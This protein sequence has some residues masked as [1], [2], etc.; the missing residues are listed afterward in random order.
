MYEDCAQAR[1]SIEMEQYILNNDEVGQKFMRLFIDKAKSGVDVHLLCDEVGSRSF[2]N[3]DMV[4]S[5]RQSGGHF[6][7]YNSLKFIDLFKPQRFFPRTHAKALVIDGAIGYIGGV[8]FAKEMAGWRDTQIRVTGPVVQQMQEALQRN[9]RSGG[10]APRPDKYQHEDIHGRDFH[11]IQNDPGW[12]RHP[13]YEALLEAIRNAN[14]TICISEA[15][16]IPTRRLRRYLRHAA[17]RGVEVTIL[18]PETSDFL[19]ADWVSLSYAARLLD[20]GVRI[21]HYM[22][23]NL[24]TKTVV[25]DDNWAMVGS[26]NM[27]P[28]S[29]FHNRESNLIIQDRKV[30]ETMRADF[31]NDLKS[32]NEVMLP[33]L[34]RVP[35]WKKLLGA[36]RAFAAS[37]ALMA[38]RNMKILFMNLGYGRG[39][40]GSLQHHIIYA[41][42]N[43]YCST[44]VQKQSLDQLR[45]LIA[46][47][48]PDIAC[49]VEI[50]GGSFGTAGLNQMTHLLNDVYTFADIENK[51]GRGSFWR[52]FGP[53]AGKSNG[54]LAKQKLAFEK[55]HFTCGMKRL[56]YGLRVD[57]RLT[58]FFAHFAL[59]K[60]VRARQILEATDMMRRTEG[61][62]LFLGD[63]NTLTGL[64]E[65]EPMLDGGRYILLNRHDEPTFQFHKRKLV[66][67]LAVATSELA[68]HIDLR[69][70][71]QGFSDHAALV[72]DLQN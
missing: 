16:F 9:R 70:L 64:H 1:H 18:V 4:A 46:R 39:I 54:F 11:Y 6:A 17:L 24:H 49:F 31:Q 67:D 5:L 50:D 59:K 12:F 62:T 32:S 23:T 40:D 25:V 13:I 61:E 2:I 71:P 35:L 51:Y 37:V 66:L 58:I 44:A 45:D 30:I 72:L 53:T 65:M 43:L 36:L 69:V 15:F 22:P 38:A 20:A 27:D 55:L 19:L 26:C 48:N 7:F 28:L 8:C 41:H 47:E 33:V 52:S 63:F 42:R 68:K 10:Y 29:F 60:E 34:R 14:E 56:V 3:S 21:F 57:A